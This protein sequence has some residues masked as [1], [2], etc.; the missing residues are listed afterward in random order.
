MKWICS[1][2]LTSLSLVAWSQQDYDG[3]KAAVMDYI[4]GTAQSDIDRI[5]HAF[6]PDAALFSV[7]EGDTLRR[8][9][10][11]TY[12]GFFTP[13]KDTGRKGQII[14]IDVVKNAA[15]AI[16]KIEAGN[17]YFTDYLLLLRLHDGW[18]IIHKSFT[19]ETIA[20][21]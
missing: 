3:A 12:I 10:I 17:R 1:V 4:E 21:E 15:S 20:R 11:D 13:G 2:L 19:A 6:H 8:L 16:V 18:K 5:R 14:S 9:P 7:G